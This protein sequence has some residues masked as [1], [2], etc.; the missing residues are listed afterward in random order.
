MFESGGPP[1]RPGVHIVVRPPAPCWVDLGRAFP[2]DELRRVVPDGLDLQSRVPGEVLIWSVTTTG[3]WVGYVSFAVK[4]GDHG[5]RLQ[6]WMLSTALTA[7][8]DG[9]ARPERHGGSR[10]IRRA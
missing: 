1:V 8:A 6:Q 7:R 2:I 10:G 9:P 3:H 5:V 4:H